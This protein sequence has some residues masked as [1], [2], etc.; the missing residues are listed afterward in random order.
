MKPIRYTLLGIFLLM[1]S[2]CSMLGLQRVQ[3]QKGVTQPQV[4]LV[5]QVSLPPQTFKLSL[6]GGSELNMSGDGVAR[7]VQVCV[8]VV[9]NRDWEAP[10]ARKQSTCVEPSGDPNLISSKRV[11][12]APLHMNH[13]SLPMES[14]RNSWLIM[15]ADFSQSSADDSP[16]IFPMNSQNSQLNVMLNGKTLF[17][18]PM[19]GP[20]TMSASQ[21]PASGSSTAATYPTSGSSTT[22]TNPTASSSSSQT[23]SNSEL[24]RFKPLI[25]QSVMSPSSVNVQQQGQGLI[26]EEIS[27]TLDGRK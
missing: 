14:N 13:I 24:Q 25:R 11:V 26:W 6:L 18:N 7:P 21:R 1:L 9:R 2:G 23:A 22:A 3:S 15:E 27:K 19:A 17:L 5:Q 4:Q 20:E 16:Y 10:F 8:Y 12:L